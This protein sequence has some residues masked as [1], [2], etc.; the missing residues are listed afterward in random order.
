MGAKATWYDL[1]ALWAAIFDRYRDRPA[2]GTIGA[3]VVSLALAAEDLL[4][5]DETGAASLIRRGHELLE[6][7]GEPLAS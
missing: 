5:N 7:L 2:I 1:E 3:E 6:D 4:R